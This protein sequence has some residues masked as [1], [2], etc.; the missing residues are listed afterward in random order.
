V[1]KLAFYVVVMIVSVIVSGFLADNIKKN[2]KEIDKAV[3]EL[4][5]HERHQD[6]LER[7]RR[8]QRGK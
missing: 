3:E 7:K 6:Y 2:K 5:K 1:I 8:I 4:K